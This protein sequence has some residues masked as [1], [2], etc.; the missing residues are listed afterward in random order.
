MIF[1]GK[2]PRDAVV[3]KRPEFL[4]PPIVQYA[5]PLAG[6]KF[7]DPVA[8]LKYRCPVA[9]VAGVSS[10]DPSLMSAERPGR[11][12]EAVARPGRPARQRGHIRPDE[13]GRISKCGVDLNVETGTEMVLAQAA[14]PLTS[15]P[16]D[17]VSETWPK[18]AIISVAAKVR[19]AGCDR[20]NQD[21]D[22][23]TTSLIGCLGKAHFPSFLWGFVTHP[24]HASLRSLA[25]AAWGIAGRMCRIGS[26][27]PR[28]G[29]R[30]SLRS[31]HS[32]LLPQTSSGEERPHSD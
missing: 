13:R 15:L 6:Q 27:E 14:N 24:D 12:G 31:S 19:N 30:F 28:F 26:G 3:M 7:R 32:R 9:P 25:D 22:C 18:T 4:D 10:P 21:Q 20:S 11:N 29:T 2:A 23:V 16:S 17:V 8:A 1:A 5:R